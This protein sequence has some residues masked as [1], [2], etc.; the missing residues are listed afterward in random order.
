L[1]LDS[2]VCIDSINKMSLNS[3][4]RYKK[5]ENE[6]DE[7]YYLSLYFKP[8]YDEE[9][10][11]GSSDEIDFSTMLTFILDIADGDKR[12]ELKMKFLTLF[13]KEDRENLLNYPYEFLS[14]TQQNKVFH[15]ILYKKCLEL[16]KHDNHHDN[17]VE[18]CK[19]IVTLYNEKKKE[20]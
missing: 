19:F 2:L 18:F 15:S 11:V 1:N 3:E 12:E 14:E 5:K 20:Q 6:K 4:S 7:N 17:L 9:E 16:L 8:F 13:L 10:I